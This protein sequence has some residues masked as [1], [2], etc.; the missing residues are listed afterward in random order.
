[1]KVCFFSCQYPPL[2]RTW[3]R[4]MFARYLADGGCDVEVVA[5]GNISQA[6][7]S[8]TDDPDLARE[9]PGIPVHRV[10]ALPWH[11]AGEVLYR[12]GAIPCPYLNW[13]KSLISPRS[14]FTV[15]SGQWWA[16]R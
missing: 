8:F 12:S 13:Q 6:L 7:G 11:L 9:D 15:S 16:R 14:T 3:R 5:H 10:R 1:M 2:S 4:Y